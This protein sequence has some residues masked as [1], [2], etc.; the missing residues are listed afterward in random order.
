MF[1]NIV[2][3]G[4]IRKSLRF[5]NEN[6]SLNF[7]YNGLQTT[8]TIQVIINNELYYIYDFKNQFINY[9]K[10]NECELTSCKVNNINTSVY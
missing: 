7:K 1:R 2:N 10:H 3:N 8:D 5:D 6:N 4:K 9:P